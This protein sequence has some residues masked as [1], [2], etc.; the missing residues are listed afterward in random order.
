M[1]LIA[2]FNVVLTNTDVVMLG[3]YVSNET[4]GLYQ[5]AVRL[6]NL[7]VFGLL[8]IN[9]VIQPLIAE[10][11]TKGEIERLKYLVGI[12]CLAS[13]AITVPVIIGLLLFGAELIAITFGP[14]YISAFGPLIVILVSQTLNTGFG[15]VGL[16]L[17]M[18]G[19]E[20]LMLS[21]LAL[22]AILNVCLNAALIP[23]FGIMGAAYASL[24][25]MVV[26]NFLLWITVR[27][28]LGFDASATVALA[29]LVGL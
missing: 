26:R 16:L 13:L 23:T 5:I 25:A 2:G 10:A 29:R 19:H 21:S 9:M 11:Y 18:T 14:N 3:A 4:V 6:G 27:R 7:A 1:S 12:T 24:A 15:P 22:T 20:K 28:K 8:A 17:T